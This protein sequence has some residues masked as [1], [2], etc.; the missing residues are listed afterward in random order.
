MNLR[1]ISFSFLF[2]FFTF[3]IAYSQNTGDCS[4][5]VNICT[6]ASFQ[7]SPNGFGAIDELNGNVSNPSTN[8][9]SGNSGCLLSGELNSTWMIINIASSGTLEFSFGQDNSIGCLDWIMWPYNA[10]ACA[11]IF[12]NTL[13]PIR[14]NWNGMCEGFSGVATPLPVGGEASNFEPELNVLAGEQYLVCLSNFSSQTTTVPLDFF[15]TASVSCTTVI[16]ITV[17]SGTIC[18]GDS[19]TLTA[20]GATTYVWSPGNQ[21]TSSITVSPSVTTNYTVT[22]TDSTGSGIGNSTVT[23][24][25]ANDPLCGCTV[26]ASNSSPVCSGDS[27]DLSATIIA[28]ATYSWTGPNSFSANGSSLNNIPSLSVGNHTFVVVATDANGNS[29]IDSTTVTINPLP[30][31]NAGPDAT[32]CFNQNHV[33]NASG[34][35]SYSWTG[36]VQNGQSFVVQNSAI[37]TVTGTDLNGCQG[38]D[39]MTLT[40]ASASVP[41]ISPSATLGCIPFE[42][43]YTNQTIDAQNCQWSF[44]NSLTVANSCGDQTTTYDTEGCFDVTLMVENSFGCDT[45]VTFPSIVCT[46]TATASFYASPSIIGSSNQT[47]SF[48]NLSENATTYL[49]DFGDGSSTSNEFE[50]THDYP[51]GQGQGYL[52]T[53][54]AYST[55]GCSDTATFVI[56]YEEQLIFYVPN[57]FTPDEDQF[58]QSFKPVFHS[59]FD[60]LSFH[61]QIFNRWGE[62]VWESYDVDIG[63]DGSYGKNGRPSQ[64]GIYTWMISFRPK[65]TVDKTKVTGS[66][67]L[68]R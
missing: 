63:W 29:C 55:A 10:T 12:N 41:S 26:T 58:N 39:Q 7:V 3:N 61:M 57:T 34:A 38:A 32:V 54:V 17:N 6:N 27:F 33:L 30:V 8:P 42:V 50:P 15:G 5:A 35:N 45:S 4:G 47:V 11:D 49:W 25:N 19:I 9:A 67:L 20:S 22:G 52:P 51:T 24:L 62:L 31:V 53:L 44:G 68:M 18:P 60:K 59:G 23:V 28:G 48:Y 46:E 64:Q 36:G 14:C 37:Y 16:P 21:T 1:L 40:M 65:N 66:I 13:A 43:T 56:N 2:S